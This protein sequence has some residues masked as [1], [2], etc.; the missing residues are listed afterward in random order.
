ML[1]N[2]K[3]FVKMMFMIIGGV[4]GVL[5]LIAGILNG[6]F[7]EKKYLNL[8]D[9][10]Y[11][12]GLATDQHRIIADAIKAASSHNMQPWLIEEISDETVKLYAD[13][14]KDLNVID[15]YH[16]QMLMSHGT[17][18]E[19][20]VS[21]AASK[22]YKVTIDYGTMD[23][24]AEQPHIATMTLLPLEEGEE[25][26]AV[27]AS[28]FNP[29]KGSMSTDKLNALLNEMTSDK[30]ELSMIQEAVKVTELQTYLREATRIESYDRAATEEL[31]EVFRFTESEK[32]KHRYGL[33]LSSMAPALRLFVQPMM[34]YT[35]VDYEAFAKQSVDMFES[36]LASEYAYVLIKKASPEAVDFIETGRLYQRL[37]FQA[38]GLT[39]RPNVQVLEEYE[40]MLELNKDF[41]DSYGKDGEVL[42]ILGVQ[43]AGE[44]Q[45][46]QTPRHMVE[47]I[48]LNK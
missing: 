6:S 47:D 15:P 39:I 37:M 17:F 3:G 4:L 33:T 22:G 27:S 40:P 16:K 10:T 21:A 34:Q 7:E 43:K 23:F 29:G 11:I 26:D 38:Y 25:V 30:M 48:L 36:R 9:P 28:S 2:R 41:A 42:L 14:S 44:S 20:Y 45:G 46:N 32:N 13:M 5:V 24:E 31:L 35:E 18:I 8:W 19:Y 12:Q 1:K